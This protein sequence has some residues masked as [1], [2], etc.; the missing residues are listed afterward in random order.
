MPLQPYPSISKIAALSA[1]EGHVVGVES[2][3]TV[4]ETGTAKITFHKDRK[5]TDGD[6]QEIEIGEAVKK[7]KIKL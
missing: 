3:K 2:D 4:I 6:D 7:L 5:I 1:R